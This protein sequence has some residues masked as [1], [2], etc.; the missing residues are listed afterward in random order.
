MKI[1]SQNWIRFQF[2]NVV[3]KYNFPNLDMKRSR[4]QQDCMFIDNVSA[5][6]CVCFFPLMSK[7]IIVQGNSHSKCHEK[8]KV[9]N[10]N[11]FCHLNSFP[12]NYRSINFKRNFW[13]FQFSKKTNEKCLP[14]QSRA[15]I[16]IISQFFG[17]IKEIS[18]L[19]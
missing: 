13:C 16:N 9:C 10:S 14:Q 18:F 19:D 4:M 15:K 3:F 2:C 11:T 17:R 6:L 5:K 1:H 12:A 8:S 7:L